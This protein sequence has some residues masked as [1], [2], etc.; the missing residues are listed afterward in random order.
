LAGKTIFE[1]V[2]KLGGHLPDVEESTMF[3]KPALKVR[4][5]MFAC[6]PSNKSAEPDSLVVRMDFEQRA[7]LLAA[8]PAVYY[9]T[10]H[11]VGYPA[12]LIRLPRVQPDALR[13]LLAMAHRFVLR[14]S[15]KPRQ[16]RSG[17]GR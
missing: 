4:G 2:R 7:E 3:G 11:Y 10:E 13:D 8:D 5:K 6:L 1:I 17:A 9:I 15:R 14:E 12:V 16:P